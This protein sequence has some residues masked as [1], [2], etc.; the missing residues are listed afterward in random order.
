MLNVCCVCVGEGYSPTYVEVLYSMIRRNLSAG[1]RGRFIVFTDNPSAFASMAGVQTRRVPERFKGWW[2]KL[3]LFSP[4]AFLKG[5]RVLYFDLD[6]VITGDLDAIAGYTGPFTMLQD[7]YRKSGFQSSVM[8]WQAGSMMTSMCWDDWADA[9]YP[10]VDGGDQAWIEATMPIDQPLQ[11][12]FPKKFRSYKLDCMEFVP[13]GTAVVFF[14]GQPKP[15]ECLNWV[16]EVW[17]L[18]DEKLFFALNVKEDALK[19]NIQH[20]LDKP[21]WLKKRDGTAL[22]AVI[23]GGG[24]SLANDGWRIRGY[25]LS[26]A[27]VFA[28]NNTYRYLKEQ[29]ITP[30]CHVMHDAREANLEFVPAEGPCYYASQCHPTVLDAAGSRLICWHP[31]SE[32]CLEVLGDNPTGPIMV[33]G[34]STVG[35]NAIA[36]AYILGHRHFMLFGF[37]SS[38]SGGGHH[39]Y[40]QK[41]NDG[42]LILEVQAYGETFQAAPW[43]IQQ[44]EQFCALARQLIQLGCTFSV[45]GE[46]LLPTMAANM[47]PELTPADLRARSILERLKGHSQPVGAEIGVFAGELAQRLLQRLDLSL[48]LVDSWAV[49]NPDSQYAKS[50]DFHAQLRR[51]E[52]EHFYTLAKEMTSFAG[53]RATILRKPSVEAAAD[54]PDGSLD[55]V[56]IDAD[57]SYEGCKA[58]IEAWAP[59]VKLGGLIAGHDYENT[60][61]PKFG[62]TRAVNELFPQVDLGENFTWFVRK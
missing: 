53:G 6:T 17:K 59:K 54:I 3:Y 48:Y 4:G 26:G 2:A 45:S 49:A 24:P 30:D 9:G 18:S 46:G 12:L 51:S 22:S 47:A 8:A 62:V 10:E 56:F 28:T 39:A 43:M 25:Q 16:R 14:H 36:L 19:A 61:F 33:A 50:G 21:T 31:Y 44:A 35:L 32:S 58:D 20:A 55:F 52:Q 15:H 34:G 23:V 60:D 1:F 5:E 57:H 38:Y 13:R 42:E 37:D 40:A 41:L 29:G 11:A 7:A 27:V